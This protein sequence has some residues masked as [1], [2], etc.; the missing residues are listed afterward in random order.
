MLVG[1]FGENTTVNAFPSGPTYTDSVDT[2]G[3]LGCEDGAGDPDS[4]VCFVPSNPCD[5]TVTLVVPGGS[6]SS[7]NAIA[8]LVNELTGEC[9]PVSNCEA[10]DV[11]EVTVSLEKD[12]LWCFVGSIGSGDQATS[13]YEIQS[14]DDCGTLQP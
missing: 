3:I 9:T 14:L 12:K 4:V 8:A 2:T 13:T 10:G 6:P 11:S 5:V 7:V 1:M